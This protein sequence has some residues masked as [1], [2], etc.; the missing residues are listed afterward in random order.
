[1]QARSNGDAQRSCEG[2]LAPAQATQRVAVT[3]L[4]HLRPQRLREIVGGSG[5]GTCVLLGN[6]SIVVKTGT[7]FRPEVCDC[8]R[9]RRPPVI[10]T[11]D[12][13]AVKAIPWLA[14]LR[15]P[16]L[17]LHRVGRDG[18]GAFRL[19]QRPSAGEFPGGFP[20]KPYHRSL[21]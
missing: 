4:Q 7:T 21:R 20:A 11:N 9:S 15:F 14:G 17:S 3:G 19:Q 13:D 16:P 12:E 2:W 1:M 5:E 18:G 6:R 8:Q 10:M